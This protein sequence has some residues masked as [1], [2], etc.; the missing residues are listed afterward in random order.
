MAF[1]IAM[2]ALV[3]ARP[4]VA[5]Q[6][7]VIRGQVTASSTEQPIAGAAITA[8]TLSGGVNR[9]ART[10]DHGRYTI[11]FPRGDGDY[12]IT[13]RAIGYVPRRFELKRVAD[14]DILIGDVR[15][16]AASSTLD[17]VT[18]L[19][20]RDRPRRADSSADIG[21][22][23]RLVNTS[24]VAIENLGNLASMAASTPGLLFLP[25]TDGDPAGY[26]VFGL[27]ET[28]NTVS[29]NGMNSSA[30]DLPRDGDYAVTVALSPYDVSQGQFSGGRTN[31]RVSAGSNFIKRTGSL[32]L[33]APP[34]EWTDAAGRSLG[35]QYTNGNLGAGISGPISYD[36]AFY[37]LSVQLGQ[38]ANDLHTLLN[39]DPLGLETSGIAADS[40]ARLVG[41]LGGKHAPATVAGF[42]G[43]KLGSQGLLLGSFDFL[44]PSSTS[45]QSFNLTLNGGWNRLSPAST[46]TSAVPASAFNNTSWNG[47]VQGHHTAYFGFGVLS[48]TGVA[49]SEV[50]RYSSPYLDLPSGLVTV[51]SSFADGTSG[52]EPIT[53]GGTTVDNSATTTS[54]E[55]SNVLSWFSENNKHRIKLT[56]DVRRDAFGIEQ[57]SNTLGTFTFNSLADLAADRPTSFTRQ[58]APVRTNEDEL[59]AGVSLGDSYRPS[60]DLQLVYGA[61]ADLNRFLDA[62]ATNAGVAQLYGVGND[63][64]PNRV[65]WSPRVGFAWTYGAVPTLG[66][67]DG[68]ARIPRAVIRGGVGVF[69]GTPSSG[70]TSQTRANTGLLN[71]TQ[72]LTCVGAGVPVPEWGT[73]AS[74]PASIPTTCVGGGGAAF[75]NQVPNVTLFAPGYRAPRSIRSNLQWMGALLGDRVATTINATY[76]RNQNQPGFVDLNLDST[77]KFTL[78]EEGDR[79]VFV[80]AASIVSANG[81]IAGTGSRLSPQFNHVT[82]LQSNLSSTARQLQI[83]LGPT[84]VSTHYTWG[85]AYTLNSV[86]DQQNGFSSGA[87]NPFDVASGRSLF[88]WRH[89]LQVSVGYNAF[90]VV[91]LN[92][93]QTFLSGLPYTPTVAGDV[94]GDGYATND[95][96]FIFDPAHTTDTAV[97]S[98]MSKLLQSGAGGVRDC[99]ERQLGQVAGRSS[100]EAPWTST[101]NLRID[102]N[103]VRVRMPERTMLSFSIANPLGAAD[104]LLHGENHIHGWGQFL[105]PDNQLLYVRGF[106]QATR[107]FVY[108]VNPR[109][110]NT[111]PAVSAL[112]SPVALTALVRIDLGPTRERQTLTRTLDEGRKTA[113]PKAT[114]AELRA[115][116]G[117][118]GLI[119]PMAVILRA[120]DSL[121]LTGK[122]ADSIATLNRWY[123]VHLDSIW[124]P[125]VH[126]YA[127]LP[128]RYSQSAAYGRYVRARE[129][130]VDLL[131]RLAPAISGVLT[132]AQRRK[133]PPLTAAH[134]DVRYL[135]AVRAGTPNLSA[136]VFPPPAG[137]AG[138]R[139][140]GRGGG[141]H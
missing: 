105:L 83:V 14:E 50:R 16:S 106:N 29:L 120:S 30:T 127:A 72:Q 60:T 136:P 84:G 46:L 1:V 115:A 130:S 119:N 21:G 8:T 61:R 66:A 128:D 98:A 131:I 70:L 42:P 138:E 18:T 74:D 82:E 19:G 140:G 79:P 32:L 104:L 126:A 92:W 10:D 89:Q 110:G 141:G 38:T 132:P 103:P 139:G 25:G 76:S 129:A 62:P 41:I 39:T 35:Q 6:A 116:Y 124:S 43:S 52:V 117:L 112:R 57:G 69:Q 3:P 107:S 125:V 99:L 100:C 75:N 31:V 95:R 65:E 113:G 28:Q 54:A 11:P 9:S 51:A 59:L 135:A 37:N 114:A 88:D 87:G 121:H 101:A 49:L 44:S 93:F 5:Q 24:N 64:L 55:A 23:D 102:F 77:A 33:D 67:F 20:R 68:A 53:F 96:A 47:A 26:S 71:G 7:D 27:D 45:G 56:T 85:L 91:R 40:V 122:Q 134:L 22:L 94:N 36:E 86:H 137:T 4:L 111:S 17:T 90:D 78:P 12:V 2:G 58:L 13:V 80:A 109:F 81:A 48:E 73:F 63:A 34:L 133:L 108:Q 118:G 97:A 123:L 15:L